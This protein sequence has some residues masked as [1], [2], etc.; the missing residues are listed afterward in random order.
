MVLI[1][2][3]IF[4]F[5]SV[6]N[7]EM[8]QSLSNR[9][10]KGLC[11]HVLPH[12]PLIATSSM[13]CGIGGSKELRT[14][15]IFVFI[16][17]KFGNSSM[18]SSLSIKSATTLSYDLLVGTVGPLLISSLMELNTCPSR[19]TASSAAWL[20]WSYWNQQW[21]DKNCLIIIPCSRIGQ[22]TKTTG[23]KWRVQ[24]GVGTPS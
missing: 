2:C 6:T 5:A 3:R 7:T 24:K 11:A 13:A 9:L 18:P 17:W 15:W 10:R 1:L 14:L 12:S 19:M 20:C 8:P 22:K 23:L 21:K 4:R 16:C